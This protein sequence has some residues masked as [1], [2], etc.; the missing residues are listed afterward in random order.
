MA[1]PGPFR[2][3]FHL[4]VALLLVGSLGHG[5]VQAL[6]RPLLPTL[7]APANKACRPLDVHLALTGDPTSLQVSWRTAKSGCPCSLKFWRLDENDMPLDAPPS[8]N[9]L[10]G[11]T[12]SYSNKDMCSSPAR[13]IVYDPLW[14]HSVTLTG[15][16]PGALYRYKIKSGSSII[17]RAPPAPAPSAALKFIAF[18]DM[19]E[20]EHRVAKS[21]GASDT[22][23]ALAHELRTWDLQL[24]YHI[25]DLAYANGRATTGAGAAARTARPDASG[26][27]RPYDPDWGNYGNDSGGECGVAAAMR[28][29]MPGDS[30]EASRWAR[31][32]HWNATG[33]CGN[34]SLERR[35][36][37]V[38]SPAC[39]MSG[40]ETPSAETPGAAA[41]AAAGVAGLMPVDDA[42]KSIT[43][44]PASRLAS[45]DLSSPEPANPPFWYGFSVGPAR[46]VTLSTEHDFTPGSR[47][48]RW[49]RRELRSV[50]RCR[51]PWLIVGMHRPM[52]VVFPHKSNRVVGAHLR[53]VLEPLFNRYEV[54]LVLSGHVH[55]YSRSCNVLG[56]A[57]LPPAEGGATHVTA[58]TGGRKLSFVSADQF[59]W[60]EHSEERW[61][62]VRADIQPGGSLDLE[63]VSSESEL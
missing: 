13:D 39:D 59:E 46:F 53:R 32:A 9:E 45:D 1:A 60:V 25:G 41:A 24:V 58:G 2:G 22:M 48:H 54:D 49:L 62:Y 20:S 30:A 44:N 17:F 23:A 14:L 27:L 51:T 10:V 55:S 29:Q 18:G 33:A 19:G 43:S 3:S 16:E 61:G 6:P 7:A 56:D 50:D 21:P 36:G 5:V 12:S 57:C 26:A 47:Q 28:F 34:P 15:L 37:A 4:V 31:N 8:S 63:F 52:Y 11:S 35:A 42:E 40:A 38:P